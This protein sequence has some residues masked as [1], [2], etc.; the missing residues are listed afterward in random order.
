MSLDLK[1]LS[2]TVAHALRHE[3]WLYA[4]EL[5]ADGFVGVD[6]LIDAVRASGAPWRDLQ[7]ADVE[8]M[9]EASPKNRYQLAGDRIRARYGH[10]TP[11][12][13][14]LPPATPPDLLYHGTSPDAAERI[15]AEGLIARTR[16]YVH[17][18]VSRAGAEEVGRRKCRTPVMLVVDAAAAHAAGVVFY[19]GNEH[20]WL[21]DAVPPRF[22]GR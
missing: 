3:P 22:I 10:S 1:A 16:Q 8:R 11:G 12:R 21:A 9:V 13:V 2:K 15:A 4:L 18:A 6:E 17:L 20:V 14:A 7:R 5:D 19:R